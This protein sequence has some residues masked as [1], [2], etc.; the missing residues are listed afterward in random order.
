M[1]S[2]IPLISSIAA[3]IAGTLTL[4]L[5]QKKRERTFLV[6][7]AS[8]YLFFIGAFLEFV[9][10]YLAY[11]PEILYRIYYGTSPIQPGLLATAL[12][13]IYT[14]DEFTRHRKLYKAYMGYV[15][16]LGSIVFLLSLIAEINTPLL[17]NPY[18]GGAAMAP[19]VRILSPPLTIP[20][21]II[22][23]GYPIYTYFKGNKEVDK[24]LFPL[25]ALIVAIGGAMIRRGLVTLFYLFELGGALLL[26]IA[27]YLVYKRYSK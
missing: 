7:T 6:A 15:A 20:S 24:L 4:H 25:A 11:W 19:Y 1:T 16:V 26:L 18:V 27:F 21:G 10:S 14:L 17:S 3:F 13:G 5:F 2:Y 8:M 12:L 9:S 22:M 23:I